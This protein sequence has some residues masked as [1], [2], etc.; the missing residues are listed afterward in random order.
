MTN[1]TA[2]GPAAG[3]LSPATKVNALAMVVA[4]AASLWFN[5]WMPTDAHT[6]AALVHLASARD[7]RRA[8]FDANWPGA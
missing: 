7:S 6:A 5:D 8:F 1:L 2:S 4:I 3:S